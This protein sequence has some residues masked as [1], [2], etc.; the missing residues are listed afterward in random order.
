MI[1]NFDPFPTF[2]TDRLILRRLDANDADDLFQLRTDAGVNRYLLRTPPTSM[3]EVYDYI[4]KIDS[5]LA[6]NIAA[7]WVL[8]LK[9]DNKLMGTICLWNFDKEKDMADIGYEL[10]P[11]YQGHGFMQ[12]AVEKVI[13][14]GFSIMQLKTILGLTDPGNERSAALLKRNGFKEDKAYQYVSKDDAGNDVVYFL[15][16]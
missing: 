11:E 15:I 8:C 9:N 13:D 7:Y 10:S 5:N 1:T 14:Y 2:T 3:D 12:E 4:K 6:E 16:K